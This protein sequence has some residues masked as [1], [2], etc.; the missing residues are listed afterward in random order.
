MDENKLSFKSIII[1]DVRYKTLL[2]KKF[3]ER[4]S[5]TIKNP[6]KIT[7]FIPGGIRNIHVKKGRRIKEG[8]KLLTLEAMKMCN[9]ILSPLKGT[10]KDI[11]VQ[12][13]DNVAKDQILLEFK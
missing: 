11:Y 8:E 5:Y 12:I 4:K 1:E 7:A 3:E 6:K 9:E 2:T 10:V 13:G